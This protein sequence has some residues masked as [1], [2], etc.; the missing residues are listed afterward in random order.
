M[1]RLLKLTVILGVVL[2]LGY[3][4][5]FRTDWFIIRAFEVQANDDRGEW[6]AENYKRY[7]DS[8]HIFLVSLEEGA[9]SLRSDPAVRSAEIRR[10][11]PGS[12]IYQIDYRIPIA[13]FAFEDM[14]LLV[15]KDGYL[16]NTSREAP[17]HIP[18]VMG[19]KMDS[20]VTGK[21]VD[22]V[23]K[24]QLK[25][26]LDL[27]ALLG[28]ASLEKECR[29]VMEEQTVL[30][31]LKS[32]ISGRFWYRGDIEDGFNRFMSVYNDQMKKGVVSGLIDV[33][34]EGYPVYKPFG[35]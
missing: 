32:G 34:S 30:I 24:H 28:N 5:V 22:T 1:I 35:E 19:L 27:V 20:F 6:I 33:S 7:Y 23:Q 21:P 16:V 4:A 10:K 2:G 14:T 9:D 11:L 31:S 29:L 18:Q 12:L 17:T 8:R 26:V 15:D 13:G 3:L 25:V